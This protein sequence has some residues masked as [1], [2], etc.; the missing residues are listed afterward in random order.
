[1]RHSTVSSATFGDRKHHIQDHGKDAASHG[2][3]RLGEQVHHRDDEQGERYKAQTHRNLHPADMEI[4]GDLELA[5]ARTG[6]TQ[7]QHRQAVHGKAPDHAESVQV[8]QEV[9]V[10]AADHNGED[11]QAHHDV[12]D[13]MAGAKAPVRLPEPFAQHAIFGNPVEHAVGA[14]DGGVY[15]AG[16]NQ[17]ADHH[18]ERMENQARH[19]RTLQAHG[20][21]ADEIL[22]VVLPHIV[23]NNH[24]REEGNQ[25]G[26][27][28]AVDE[29]DQSGFFEVLELGT[30]DFAID[31]GER[32]FSA[33]GQY[34]MAQSDEDGDDA[35]HVRQ[36]AVRQPAERARA[37][38][39]I[40]RIGKRW[41]LRMPQHRSIDAPADQ[42][43]HH[44]GNQLHDVQRFF[45][46]FR[47]AFDIFPPEINGDDDRKGGGDAGDRG[48]REGSA[49]VRM[50]REFAEQT[51]EILSGGDAADRAS[52][53]VIEH[54]RGDAEFRQRS[55]ERLLDRAVHAT[56]HEHAAAFHVHRAHRVGKQHDGQDEPGSGFADV[57]FRLAAR[58]VR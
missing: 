4:E 1:M 55:T 12:D 33:H 43:H 50:L 13:A 28:Q 37:E 17:R 16:Q 24:H 3:H 9:D 42:E 29:N 27:H 7:D 49:Q 52:E 30:L 53:D 2:G 19:Q 11:L 46:R 44:H 38:M 45:A 10:A 15:R 18:H 40:S 23:G 31:L 48:F 25:R 6:V 54:Q 57:P 56:A 47:H 5:L 20:Q 51:A 32:F 39:K 21:A 58:V 8:G 14:H 26:K 41:K 22:Q 35:E 34:G 36:A